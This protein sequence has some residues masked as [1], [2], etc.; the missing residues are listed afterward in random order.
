MDIFLNIFESYGWLGIAGILLAMLA[1]IGIK[2]L[3]K[4]LSKDLETGFNRVGEKLTEQMSK[5]N[6][7]LVNTIVN[8]QEKLVNYLINK[9]EDDS[10]RHNEMLNERMILANDINIG[11]KD[12]M[13]IHNAQ[14]AFILEFH[15]SN[16]NLS[17]IPFAKY[18]C[19]YE[20]FV[21][22]LTPIGHRCINLS[23]GSI[24]H[25]VND[26][27]N[28]NNQQ[29]VYTDLGKMIDDQPILTALWKDEHV[30]TVIYTGLFDKNNLLIG[31]LVLEYQTQVNINK[32]NLHQ[33]NV[34]AAEL[35]SII[36]LRYKYNK[37]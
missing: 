5:Q 21:K 29:V 3:N 1:F 13:N 10:K 16:Q 27:L 8:Q 31:L 7:Q 36:N 22:G 37:L 35:T 9:D 34:Q 26:I 25:I 6:D 19:N 33:L 12:I 30:N 2:Y 17:G 23:F 4:K 18:S 20:W 14:R 28:S 11:L 24:A 15:N 32:I